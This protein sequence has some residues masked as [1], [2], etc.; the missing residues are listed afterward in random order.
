MAGLSIGR[1]EGPEH[2][3][4]NSQPADAVIPEAG[5]TAGGS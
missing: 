4:V 5:E 3:Q 2:M 1:P